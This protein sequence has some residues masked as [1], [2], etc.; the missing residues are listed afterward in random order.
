MIAK[1]QLLNP[2]LY[3]CPN[4][5]PFHIDHPTLKDGRLELQQT[6]CANHIL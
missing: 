2:K 6:L 4:T 5:D 3:R 1:L